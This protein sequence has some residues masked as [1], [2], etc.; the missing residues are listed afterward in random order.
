MIANFLKEAQEQAIYSVEEEIAEML[1]KAS[2]W[3][4]QAAGYIAHPAKLFVKR[5]FKD[6]DRFIED[7]V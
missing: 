4:Q 3:L 5:N 7:G 1:E 2:E 6:L